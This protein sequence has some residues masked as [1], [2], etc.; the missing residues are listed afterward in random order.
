MKKI[1]WS[2]RHE[3]NFLKRLPDILIKITPDLYDH[4]FKALV[5]KIDSYLDIVRYGD[6]EY[7]PTEL[8]IFRSTH[9]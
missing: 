4:T 9:V 2:V 8:Q 5:L 1:E 7:S 3:F 6:Y